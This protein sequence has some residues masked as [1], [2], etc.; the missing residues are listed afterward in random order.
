MNDKARIWMAQDF[1]ENVL[2]EEM[3]CAKFKTSEQ[4][5]EFE[6]AFKGAARAASCAEEVRATRYTLFLL[7]L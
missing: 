2:A 3:F 4:A 1:S 7:V 6:Q 5:D